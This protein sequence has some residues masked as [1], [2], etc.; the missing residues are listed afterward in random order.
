[1]RAYFFTNMYLSSIQH[2]IQSLHCLQEINTKYQ[3]ESSI[4]TDW[5]ENH[6]TVIV[7][8]GGPS[9]KLHAIK[10][11]F[12][13]DNNTYPWGYFIEPS[14]DNALTC[15]G[16]ILPESMYAKVRYD[17]GTLDYEISQVVKSANFAR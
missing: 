15:V 7:L 16:I 11:L 14:I 1:M 6:K 4:L 10:H 5:A 17:I 13:D 9:E 12:E 3:N 8:N 2:G